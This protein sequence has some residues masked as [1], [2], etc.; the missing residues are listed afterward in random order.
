M[1]LSRVRVFGSSIVFS[2]GFLVLCLLFPSSSS[3]QTLTAVSD[4][5]TVH[6]GMSFIPVLAND[7]LGGGSPYI[8]I[9][10]APSH[11]TASAT[12]LYVA[13]TPAYGYAGSDSLTYKIC[14][15]ICS[16]VA[17][18]TITVDND[19][20]VV[21]SD[22]FFLWSN[23]SRCI[24][25]LANDYDPEN[26]TFSRDILT[27][28]S[29]A[30][31]HLSGGSPPCDLSFVSYTAG[32]ASFT[33]RA[34]DSYGI[35]S[36][37][38]GVSLYSFTAPDEMNA[39]SFCAAPVPPN[40][41]TRP[42]PDKGAPVNV[43]TG[44]MWLTQNDYQLPGIGENIEIDRF[45]NSRLQNAGLFG[46]GWYTKY[47]QS[48]KTFGTAFADKAIQHNRADGRGVLYVRSGT[49]GTFV[50]LNA[51]GR[52]EIVVN[53][54]GTY[55][56][57]FIDGRSNKFGA[58][59]KLLWQK[60]RNGNE[61][62]INY[63]TSGVLTSVTDA[64]GRTLTF[65][66]NGSGNVTEIADS[67]G[68]VATY[69]YLTSSSRL[70]TVTYPD[71]SKYKFEY[72]TVGGTYYLATVKDAL[73][74]ILETHAYDS[75]GRATTSEVDGGVNKYTFDYSNLS[76][77]Q[78]KATDGLGRETKYTF[79]KKRGANLI[80]SMEVSADAA[81]AGRRQR[82]TPT[83]GGQTLLKKLMHFQTRRLIIMTAVQI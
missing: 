71:G 7:D 9:V 65:T 77:G 75:S 15:S 4:T 60:D 72:T 80:T 35:C 43:T 8:T 36:G 69:E 23:T 44:N 11:G 1:R 39:G 64:L 49:S 12:S 52:G 17:T 21:A 25:I 74:N 6:G 3:A 42:S 73:D 5:A 61:T 24:D 57:T 83:T 59:G 68:S 54:D 55:T 50:N 70:K 47:D 37:S 41:P 67:T 14:L 53:T 27:Y 48:I 76:S 22:F 79:D 62:T 46:T 81:V 66:L 56:Q 18:V 31:G 32:Y 58:N 28:P 40:S 34:C 29:S 20:P 38:T 10:S 45:Y 16:N 13:Y 63:N 78:A 33:Y 2:M 30:M 51:E 19:A 26:D 82:P